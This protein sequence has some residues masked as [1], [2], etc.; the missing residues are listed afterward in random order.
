MCGLTVT[1]FKVSN[2]WKRFPLFKWDLT[3]SPPA[4]PPQMG[5]KRRHFAQ[6]YFLGE[7]N[8]YSHAQVGGGCGDWHW[9]VHQAHVVPQG[10]RLFSGYQTQLASLIII[11]WIVIYPVDS[12]IQCSN[13]R[14]HVHHNLFPRDF[15]FRLV[16][17]QPVARVTLAG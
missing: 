8:I 17:S 12:A 2:L 3:L 5:D 14:G 4:V 6:K 10:K 15:S 11:R 7:W 1:N 13:N 9:L 16:A